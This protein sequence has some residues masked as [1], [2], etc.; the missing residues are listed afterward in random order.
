MDLHD[1][2]VFF[3]NDPVLDGYSGAYLFD[4]QVASFD[5]SSS[6]G[7]TNRRRVLSTGPDVTIPTRRVVSIHG[8][9]WIVG[10]GTPDGFLGD[11]IRQHFNTKRATDLMALLTPAQALAAAAGTAAYAQRMY[12]KDTINALTDSEYDAQWNIFLAPG[13]PASK[14]TFLRDANAR[15]YR[16]RNDYVPTEGLR[17]LESDE[18]DAD[19][20]RACTFSTGTF[21][22]ITET[23]SAGSS[24]VN[25]IA[26]DTPKFFRF[27]HVSDERIQPGDM[28]LFVPAA[29]TLKQGATFTMAG[30]LWRAMSVQ[31]E[32]DAQVAHVRI[33]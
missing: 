15:L 11:V 12:L 13:E 10:T 27:R 26:V 22:P 6:D 30:V 21:D 3:D 14:G 9:R 16:V 33:A 17:I 7:A 25:C 5:D 1:A 18:L 4:A 20:V 23:M 24:T 19:A 8:D 31:P 2:A 29:I 32:I 28:A